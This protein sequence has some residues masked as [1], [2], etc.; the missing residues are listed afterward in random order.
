[1]GKIIR[2]D[3]KLANMIAAGEVVERISNVVKELVEN[4]IDAN[5]TQITVILEEAGLRKIQVV[6]NGS[7]MDHTDALLA[8]ERHATSKIKNEYDLFHIHSLGFRGEALPSI[9]S[10]SHI[11]LETTIK[12]EEG[13]AL[14]FEYSQLLSR[15]TSS[16]SSGTSITVTKLFYNTPARFKYLKSPQSE[17][18]QIQD[19][20][21]QFALSY[22]SI[23]FSLSNQDKI[24][25]QTSGN[26]Q[27]IEVLAK[28]YGIETAKAMKH[29]ETQNRDYHV[30]VYYSLPTQHRSSKQYITFSV[31]HRVVKN[32]RLAKDIIQAYDQL[33]PHNRYPIVFIDIIVDPLLI[34]VN[35]HPSKQEIKFSEEATLGRLIYEH[36]RNHLHQ[37]EIIPK[38]T[39]IK[40]TPVI[41]ETFEF[42][43]YVSPTKKETP[44]V[45]NQIIE[46]SEPMILEEEQT[47]INVPSPS[48][49]SKRLPELSYIGQYHGTYLLFQNQ[50]S[51]FLMDQHAAAERIR[52]ERYLSKMANPKPHY[53]ELLVPIKLTLSNHEVILLERY[54]DDLKQLGI[55]LQLHDDFYEITQVPAWFPRGMEMVYTEAVCRYLFETQTFTIASIRDDLA[56]LLSCKHS[57]K[58]NQY[59]SEENSYELLK[60]L[61]QC[62][63]PYTCPHGR[64]I[65]IELNNHEIEK[66]FSRVE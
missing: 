19:V 6:D 10:V 61:N 12:G 39:Q 21:N 32:H 37:S 55:V 65:L 54:L 1:M 57:L 36:L 66:W 18:A 46:E 15:K 50:N 42:T 64:P 25:F 41:Q 8:F 60:S 11:D 23:S 33:I 20:M 24:M 5:A 7:G 9:A 56:K 53:Y 58:A 48:P 43:S 63:H 44:V 35:I 59:V 62:V 30:N 31:N 47:P 3:N 13:I 4:A 14:E 27:I 38:I 17:L 2:L 26:G 16:R 40:E 34:D 51:L 52:Y 45:S 22:P 49:T 28:I 29:F